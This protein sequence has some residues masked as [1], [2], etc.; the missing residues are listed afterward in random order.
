MS[1]NQPMIFILIHE[2]IWLYATSENTIIL[3]VRPPKFFI[4]IVSSFSWNLQWSREKTKA[5]LMQ[6]FGRQTKSIMVFPKWPLG[7]FDVT[8]SPPCWWTKTK[9]L[10]LAS[11]VRPPEVV[12]FSIAIGVCRGWLKT[13]STFFLR[14]VWISLKYIYRPTFN[15]QAFRPFVFVIGV[16]WLDE[17]QLWHDFH[18]WKLFHGSQCVSVEGGPLTT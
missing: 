14:V 13:S 15:R 9:D 12:H 18:I 17:F 1:I 16:I 5:M 10:S 7:G 6:T 11:F 8:S 2:M 3:F 4:S